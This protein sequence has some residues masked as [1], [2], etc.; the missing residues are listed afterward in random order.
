MILKEAGRA[1]PQL[2]KQKRRKW[3]RYEREH[4][5]SLW[6]MDWKQLWN[7]AWWI[8]VMDDASRLIMNHAIFQQATAENTIQVL[9]QTIAKYGGAH[10]GSSQSVEANSTPT[11]PNDERKASANSN[12]T[13]PR[14]GSS[15]FSA[16]STTHRRTATGKVLRRIRTETTPIQIRG[17]VRALA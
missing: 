13:W 17:R 12:D 1:L 3:V 2:S 15:I 11:K 4:S 10:T 8:A 6:H 7:C 14:T 5:M 16:A 9:K